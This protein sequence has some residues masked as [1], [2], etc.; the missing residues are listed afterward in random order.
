MNRMEGPRTEEDCQQ[1]ADTDLEHLYK[2]YYKMYEGYN[3]RRNR[4]GSDN[5]YGVPVQPP[6]NYAKGRLPRNKEYD[7]K[8]GDERAEIIETYR[9]LDSEMEA[10]GFLVKDTKE[11]QKIKEMKN[12]L[13]YELVDIAAGINRVVRDAGEKNI[14]LL[15]GTKKEL[16]MGIKVYIEKRSHPE[17]FLELVRELLTK[18]GHLT[19]EEYKEN[20]EGKLEEETYT[21]YKEY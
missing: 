3:K 13:S 15:S 21:W 11:R 12:L 16:I 10:R 2:S 1:L 14:I 4:D 9:L 19:E 6:G 18:S 20:L 17:L 5:C 8:H 7:K